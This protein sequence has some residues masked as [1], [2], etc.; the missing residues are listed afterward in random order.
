LILLK[1][2]FSK[3]ERLTHLRTI[4]SLFRRD[5]QEVQSFFI[6]P[7]RVV[8][9][10]VCSTLPPPALPQVL[11]SVSKRNFKKAVDRNR[12]RR[13]CREAYRLQKQLLTEV[14]PENRPAQLAFLYIA[15]ETAEYAVIEKA[16]RKALRRMIPE[17]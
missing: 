7:F 6:F 15:K 17:E 9:K 1:N 2:T 3:A 14:A 11:F 8:Y 4:E 12:I 10:G 5:N 16:M 13:R